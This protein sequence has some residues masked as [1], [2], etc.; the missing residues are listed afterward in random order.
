MPRNLVDADFDVGVPFL[1]NS[2]IAT[3]IE[4]PLLVAGYALP[5]PLTS[6][7]H[8]FTEIGVWAIQSPEPIHRQRWSYVKS[9]KCKVRFR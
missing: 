4:P 2:F 6:R 5:F 1:L 8:E 3:A 9:L 7:R